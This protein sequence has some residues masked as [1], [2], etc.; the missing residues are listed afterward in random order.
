M[1]WLK[2]C[3]S[4]MVWTIFKLYLV[5][6]PLT[7]FNFQ[8]IVARCGL[9]ACKVITPRANPGLKLTDFP[10]LSW[11]FPDLRSLAPYSLGWINFAKSRPITSSSHVFTNSVI[12]N[13][14]FFSR[15]FICLLLLWGRIFLIEVKLWKKMFFL[16]FPSCF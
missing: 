8:C 12:T 5:L 10:D 14:W 3:S 4:C 9:P 2:V 15:N 11:F 7:L 16:T 6:F 13:L 1:R